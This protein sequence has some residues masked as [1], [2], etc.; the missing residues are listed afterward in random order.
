MEA[1]NIELWAVAIAEGSVAGQAIFGIERL[2]RGNRSR[3]RRNGVG[4]GR[5]IGIWRHLK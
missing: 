1:Q 2:S 5:S 3:I 4:K